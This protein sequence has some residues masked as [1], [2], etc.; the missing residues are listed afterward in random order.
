MVKLRDILITDIQ[1]YIEWFTKEIEWMDYDAPWEKEVENSLDV[2][3]RYKNIYDRTKQ[4]TDTDIRY[5][6]EIDV[7]GEHIGWVSAYIIDE[8][9]DKLAIGIDIPNK[10]N[11]GKSYGKQAMELFIDYYKNK[12]YTQIYTQTWSGNT[13]MINLALK[14]GFIEVNREYDKRIVNNKR[15]DALTFKKIV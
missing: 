4:F 15:F 5:R 8:N 2:E 3:N 13:R 14:L 12:G 1:D 10:N 7:D 6:F 11:R 9:P